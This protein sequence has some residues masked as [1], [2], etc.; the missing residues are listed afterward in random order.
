MLQVA[1]DL[2]VAGFRSGPRCARNWN[3][4]RLATYPRCCRGSAAALVARPIRGRCISSS[5]IALPGSAPALVARSFR[6]PGVKLTTRSV[7]GVRPSPRCAIGDIAC[8]NLL[9]TG[10][11]RDSVPGP[12]C[13][14]HGYAA[15]TIVTTEPLPG[16]SPG[17]RCASQSL[18]WTNGSPMALPGGLV[19]PSLRACQRVV[20]PGQDRRALPGFGS[21][22]SCATTSDQGCDQ[23]ISG[24]CRFGPRWTQG[25]HKAMP[26]SGRRCRGS[27]RPSLR[28][29][30]QLRRPGLER[31]RCRDRPRPSLRADP[32][33]VDVPAQR[34]G[35]AGVRPRP[36]LR[37]GRLSASRCRGFPALPGTIPAL[38]ARTWSRRRP[39]P[40]C[41]GVAEVRP[42]PSLC[43]D[44]RV[45]GGVVLQG[46]AGVG[47]GPRCAG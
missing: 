15:D 1:R 20:R 37:D 8:E 30:Y 12:C 7:A 41:W 46:V 34:P 33:R 27:P 26:T 6:R 44:E 11:C 40:T 14:D 28:D 35:V 22:P 43:V 4:S 24:R 10:R 3:G 16:F 19:R 39:A 29:H 47:P 21:A 13:A 23:R 5:G 45:R 18:P 42:R 9:Y 38:V 36:S 31:R 2:G 25:D 32:D 17:P